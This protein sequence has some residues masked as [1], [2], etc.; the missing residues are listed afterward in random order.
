[1]SMRVVKG[2]KGFDSIPFISISGNLYDKGTFSSASGTTC[3]PSGQNKST[4]IGR[5]YQLLPTLQ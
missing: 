2:A 5:N 4:C 3:L 1:M